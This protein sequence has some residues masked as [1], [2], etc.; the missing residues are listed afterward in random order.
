M[1]QDYR[2]LQSLQ[3]GFILRSG[4]SAIIR[5]C[6]DY[7]AAV[8]DKEGCP[9]VSQRFGK[10]LD[11]IGKLG[12]HNA[13]NKSQPTM[14]DWVLSWAKSKDATDEI[15]TIMRDDRWA[16]TD[17]QLTRF[18]AQ[19]RP[20]LEQLSD[21]ARHNQA[22]NYRSDVHSALQFLASDAQSPEVCRCF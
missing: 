21:P 18:L 14:E 20:V 19:L 8:C 5:V 13:K 7:V 4:L 9:T 3:N 17:D 12:N 22:L 6:K 1:L 11:A 16:L 10:A 2:G 15:K